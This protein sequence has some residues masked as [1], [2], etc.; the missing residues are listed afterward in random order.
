MALVNYL[1]LCLEIQ[2]SKLDNQ[3]QDFTRDHV[4]HIAF[5]NIAFAY[6]NSRMCAMQFL[7]PPS[8]SITIP[9]SYRF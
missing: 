2:N 6:D 1:R 8:S 3:L 5:G 9:L 4:R 7:L